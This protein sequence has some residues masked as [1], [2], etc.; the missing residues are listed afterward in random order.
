MCY[1]FWTKE[2][3][4]LIASIS[5]NNIDIPLVSSY[6]K[7]LGILLDDKLNGTAHLKS[8]IRKGFN[9]TKIIIS[10]AGIW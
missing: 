8:L 10:L 2:K 5:V 6:I 1:F 3:S 9:I 4:P 7:F